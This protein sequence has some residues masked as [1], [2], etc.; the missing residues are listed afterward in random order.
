MRFAFT[1]E[2]LAFRDAVRDLLDKE[3][4]PA[5]RA[6][7]VDERAP[8]ACPACG[9][10]SPTWAWSACSR[11]EATAG[12]GSTMVDLVLVLEETGRCAV[13]E[14]IVETAAV[15]VPLLGRAD[16][17]VAAGTSLRAVG[18]HRRR[19]RHRRRAASSAPTVELVP[20]PSVDGAR[21]LF[22]VR[23]TPAQV[24]GDR[25]ARRVRPR[26]RAASP[27]SSA[28]WPIACSR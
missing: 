6:R 3:C 22:E 19:D 17:T 24:D 16:L 12:S 5:R 13:P 25:A 28:G 9:S 20:R 7:R 2:Q 1:D 14:P 21:R 10:S 4:T 15:G 23:G 18:R 8:A 27:R 11:P 26:R